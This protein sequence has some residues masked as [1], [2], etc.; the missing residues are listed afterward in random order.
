MTSTGDRR[1][2][3]RRRTLIALLAA[4]AASLGGG[5]A[6]APTPA[7]AMDGQ[8][9]AGKEECSE[10]DWG[11]FEDCVDDDDN[12]SGGGGGSSDDS[13][14]SSDDDD[15]VVI[16]DDEDEGGASGVG[17]DPF[18]DGGWQTEGNDP[19]EDGGWQADG[20]DPFEEDGWQTEGDDP[21][22]DGWIVDREVTPPFS[23]EE[24]SKRWDEEFEAII[25][26]E[27]LWRAA[28]DL[29]EEESRR[30]KLEEQ[31]AA[32]GRAKARAKRAGSRSGPRKSRGTR[33][34]SKDKLRR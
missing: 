2:R 10:L 8:D 30:M 16:E 26:E 20:D 6:L 28:E 34:S 1:L 9:G 19:F 32:E 7:V 17:S 33:K 11:W 29:I 21:F 22:E 31:E 25:K 15:E 4:V 5:Q 12:A 14:S 23:K 3:W 27:A 24:Q 18:E 13:S